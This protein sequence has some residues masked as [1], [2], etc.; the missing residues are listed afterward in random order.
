VTFRAV[1][2]RYA[3]YGWR[4]AL[5]RPALEWSELSR[6]TRRGFTLSGSGRAV[7]VTPRFF[8]PGAR[9]RANGRVLRADRHGRLHV[10]VTL[11]PANRQ[12]ALTPGA[13]TPVRRTVIQLRSP[14]LNNGSAG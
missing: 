12:Q 6:A 7:V 8:A 14:Q 1:E 13:V 3:V 5:K 2:P 9:V 10:P 4:V 11:G